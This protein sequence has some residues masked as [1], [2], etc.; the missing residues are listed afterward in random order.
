MTKKVYKE[1]E[2]NMEDEM[3]IKLALMAHE[4]NITMNKMCS[5]L[6]TEYIEKRK[7][8]EDNKRRTSRSRSGR[9]GSSG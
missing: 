9:S 8:D 7:D 3:F 5:I 1:V 6:L 4:K 2:V